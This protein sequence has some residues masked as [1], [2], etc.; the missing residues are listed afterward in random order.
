M[1]E[2]VTLLKLYLPSLPENPFISWIIIGL[3][4]IAISVLVFAPCWKITKD[5]ITFFDERD[6]KKIASLPETHAL[7]QVIR[8]VHE[9]SVFK[10]LFGKAL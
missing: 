2:L 3:M 4:M 5:V 7:N 1:S 10:A 9:E 6:I 8:E